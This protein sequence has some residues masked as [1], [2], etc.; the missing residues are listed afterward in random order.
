MYTQRH[1]HETYKISPYLQISWLLGNR[2][3]KLSEKI[4]IYKHIYFYP[5]LAISC[6]Y[7]YQSHNQKIVSIRLREHSVFQ[8]FRVV[9]VRL[10]NHKTNFQTNIFFLLLQEL[11]Y[12]ILIWNS[13]KSGSSTLFA[14]FRPHLFW[15]FIYQI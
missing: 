4:S 5:F 9:L 3:T 6:L 7:D 13:K 14:H 2:T 15:K 11:T 12:Y 8:K 10:P 1:T